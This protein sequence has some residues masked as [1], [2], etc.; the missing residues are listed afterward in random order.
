MNFSL[1]P[2]ILAFPGLKLNPQCSRSWGS[3]TCFVSIVEN[4]RTHHF[5]CGLY[6]IRS[7]F[8]LII[9]DLWTIHITFVD[10]KKLGLVAF[11]Q[12]ILFLYN[13]VWLYSYANWMLLYS[14]GISR[15][16]LKYSNILALHESICLPSPSML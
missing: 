3:S 8:I 13:F 9:K 10:V 5:V 12:N 6:Q 16:S 4:S 2:S 14:L 15:N 1:V 11:L 7:D